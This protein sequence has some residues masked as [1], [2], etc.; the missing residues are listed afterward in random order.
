[1]TKRK[2]LTFHPRF[3]K[4]VLKWIW[5]VVL[6]PHGPVWHHNNRCKLVPKTE[7]PQSYTVIHVFDARSDMHVL[8][9]NNSMKRRLYTAPQVLTA[10]IMYPYSDD[11]DEIIGTQILGI[12][13]LKIQILICNNYRRVSVSMYYFHQHTWGYEAMETIPQM[14]WA[15]GSFSDELNL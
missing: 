8:Q 1:M 5:P 11:W 15:S 7:Y 4:N 9:N 2:L 13:E 6:P 12:S 3:S 14:T 10:E